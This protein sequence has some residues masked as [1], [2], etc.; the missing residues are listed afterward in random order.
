MGTAGQKVTVIDGINHLTNLKVW[1]I[2]WDDLA[3]ELELF[4]IDFDL[5]IQFDP[6]DKEHWSISESR[7]LR[8]IW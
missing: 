5:E 4:C 3:M 7:G 6:Q 1:S 8:V 2:S